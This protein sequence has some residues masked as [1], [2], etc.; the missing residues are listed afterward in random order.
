M[1]PKVSHRPQGG[2]T[3]HFGNHRFRKYS[4]NM[5]MLDLLESPLNFN[6]HMKT[7]RFFYKI[8]DQQDYSD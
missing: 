6:T 5:H 3:A 2:G 8:R 4:N 1:P 7:L